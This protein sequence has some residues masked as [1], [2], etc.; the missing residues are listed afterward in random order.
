M[1]NEDII[2]NPLPQDE[3]RSAPVIDHQELN[4][5]T[6]WL[7]METEELITKE[8]APVEYTITAM[9]NT[10]ISEDIEFIAQHQLPQHTNSSNTNYDHDFVMQLASGY[11]VYHDMISQLV[12]PYTD[13]FGYHEMSLT[14]RAILLLG[15]VEYK[16]LATP[17]SIVINECVELAKAYEDDSAGKLI[18]GIMHQMLEISQEDNKAPKKK[19]NQE[20]ITK[21][22]TSEKNK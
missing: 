22:D 3:V 1:F 6:D 19:N 21:E 7:G 4:E 9:D 11:D 16:V 20:K 18:N 14:R 2:A 8:E 12:A 13:K 5:L 10:T 15:Y 17:G